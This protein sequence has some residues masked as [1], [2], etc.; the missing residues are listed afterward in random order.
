M[1]VWLRSAGWAAGAAGDV[2]RGAARADLLF[3]LRRRGRR[4]RDRARSSARGLHGQCTPANLTVACSATSSSAAWARRSQLHRSCEASAR[5]AASPGLQLRGRLLG[6]S[7]N[8]SSACSGNSNMEQCTA[9]CKA[10]CGGHCHASCTGSPADCMGACQVQQPP[11]VAAPRRP[12][13]CATS[14]ARPRA[15]RTAPRMLT[16]GCQAQCNAGGAASS[17]TETSSTRAHLQSCE[18]QLESL[19]SPVSGSASAWM[20]GRG[21]EAEAQA[22]VASCDMAPATRLRCRRGRR[23]SGSARRAHRAW[24]AAGARAS[25]VLRAPDSAWRKLTPSPRV[26]RADPRLSVPRWRSRPTQR[27]SE[28]HGRMRERG[29]EDNYVGNSAGHRHRRGRRDRPSGAK[30]AAARRAMRAAAHGGHHDG[31]GKPGSDGGHAGPRRAGQRRR[32]R[33]QRRAHGRGH[34]RRARHGPQYLHR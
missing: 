22:G 28:S 3:R 6:D 12:D 5:V 26:G 15:T 23:A 24:C 19:L 31:G 1:S 2:C 20:P 10:S 17:A 4:W 13:P 25:N 27:H 30:E 7:D 16:G 21:R 11:R 34:G 14:T 32:R 8:C 9:E 18:S 33:K 29:N